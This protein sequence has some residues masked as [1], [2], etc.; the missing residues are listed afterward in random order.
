MEEKIKKIAEVLKTNDERA[1]EECVVLIEKLAEEASRHNTEAVRDAFE[2]FFNYETLN[3]VSNEQL[4][5]TDLKKW[6]KKEIM[7]WLE[8]CELPTSKECVYNENAVV[9]AMNHEYDVH[10]DYVN[11]TED[12]VKTAYLLAVGALCKEKMRY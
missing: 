9:V 6:S 1:I 4:R 8:D 5:N 11:S 2:V 7:Q 12:P 3:Y 10:E